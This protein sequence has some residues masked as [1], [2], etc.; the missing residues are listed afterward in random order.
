MFSTTNATSAS[1]GFTLIMQLPENNTLPALH[2]SCSRSWKRG[3]ALLLPR[4]WAACEFDEKLIW[5]FVPGAQHVFPSEYSVQLA[6]WD[7][8]G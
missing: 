8:L 2:Q 5:R 1:A 4:D 7:R 3:R 6:F